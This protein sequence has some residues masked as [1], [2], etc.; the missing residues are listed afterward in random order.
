MRRL[1]PKAE[2]VVFRSLLYVRAESPWDGMETKGTL[3][4]LTHLSLFEVDNRLDF[5]RL[6][7]YL[8]PG[9]SQ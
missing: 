8:V 2:S 4:R 7:P 9:I 1:L 6:H 3:G 5:E